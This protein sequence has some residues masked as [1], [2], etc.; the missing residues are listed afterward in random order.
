MKRSRA[1]RLVLIGSTGL[2]ALTACEAGDP[3]IGQAD[4][5]RDSQECSAKLDPDACRQGLAD[6]RAQ[7][8]ATAP[9]FTTLPECEAKFGEENCQLTEVPAGA[10]P[11]AQGQASTGGSWFMPIMMGYMMGRTASGAFA[12]TGLYR[13]GANTAYAGD[14]RMGKFDAKSVP[15]MR[16]VASAATAQ[17]SGF[18]ASGAASSAAS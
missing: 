13:D 2:V 6:A 5:F 4:F 11:Q 15:P 18:G 1:I 14:R 8:V 10:T 12:P 9:K 3:V 16:N 7:H 17:R